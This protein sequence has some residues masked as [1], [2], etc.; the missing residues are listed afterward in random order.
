MDQVIGAVC[1][2]VGVIITA[3]FKQLFKFFKD[4]F[5]CKKQAV[6]EIPITPVIIQEQNKDF[7]T[8][9]D[10]DEKSQQFYC[11]FVKKETYNE[12][13]KSVDE[14]FKAFRCELKE[15]KDAQT[16]QTGKIS[17]IDKNVALVQKDLSYLCK[18]LDNL[19]KR[20]ED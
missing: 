3:F 18:A 8:H 9:K 7:V 5:E 15:I 1:L 16:S 20:K 12:H 6:S 11:D 10:L 19:P 2:V 13:R 17:E 14:E 4:L